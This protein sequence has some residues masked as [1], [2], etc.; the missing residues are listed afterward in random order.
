MLYRLLTVGFVALAVMV[1][2]PIAGVVSTP[3]LAQAVG[4]IV[5]EGNQRVEQPLRVDGSR[6][7]ADGDDDLHDA[8]T[9]VATPDGNSA[10]VSTVA[11]PTSF[12]SAASSVG[13]RNRP[14][15]SGR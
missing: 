8:T 12:S 13:E 11:K 10:F 5:V 9:I 6:R 1:A 15:D 7:A 14:I 2:G 4:Q 3:A